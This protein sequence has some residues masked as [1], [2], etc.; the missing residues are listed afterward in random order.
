MRTNYSHIATIEK[1]ARRMARGEC[2]NCGKTVCACRK[3]KR[4]NLPEGI[5]RKGTEGLGH[6]VE[7][8]RRPSKL[9]PGVRHANVN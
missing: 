2:R 9:K 7:P 8:T 4:L 3:P 6:P 5:T 1:N